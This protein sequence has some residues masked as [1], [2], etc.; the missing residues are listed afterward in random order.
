[1]K[2]N[3]NPQVIKLI[4]ESTVPVILMVVTEDCDLKKTQAQEQV[5]KTILEVNRP[6]NFYAVCL[7]ENTL[8]F[9]APAA[10]VL[11]YYAPKNQVPAFRRLAHQ[12]KQ[13]GEDLAII[14]RMMTGLTLEQAR[15]SESEQQII[16]ETE[17]R[18]VEEEK[19]DF[20]PKF[21]MMRGLAKDMFKNAKQALAGLPVIADSEL[22]KSRYDTCLGCDKFDEATTRCRECGCAMQLKTQLVASTCPLNKW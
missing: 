18:F 4:E 6:V 8:S 7:P 12:F 11:Y 13:I 10:P 2:E 19:Q 9:P 1:M 3:T 5:E 17:A 16:T 14:E 21:K 20:P 22:A 15:Y